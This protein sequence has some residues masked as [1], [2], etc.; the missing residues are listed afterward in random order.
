GTVLTVTSGS[1][2]PLMTYLAVFLAFAF[3]PLRGKMRLVRW[4]IVLM[5]IAL[6]IVMHG[7]VWSLIAHIDVVGGNSADHRYQLV[8]QCILHFKE[9]W[10]IGTPDSVNWGW[11]MWDTADTYVS[12]AERGGLITLI[13]FFMILTRAF[14]SVGKARAAFEG[15]RKKE[16]YYWSLGAAVFTQC[17]AYFG[18]SYFDQTFLAV[19]ALLVMVVVLTANYIAAVAPETAPFPRPGHFNAIVNRWGRDKGL[20]PAQRAPNRFG[21]RG[22]ILPPL[23]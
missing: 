23:K 9:W 4:G 21:P 13:F 16:L 1:S 20:A 18:I 15:D 11:D 10:L 19:D 22:S 7:P 17:V 2:T 3:W 12:V 6:H 5:L 14:R 8:N